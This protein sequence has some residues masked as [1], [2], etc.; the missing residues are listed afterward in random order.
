MMMVTMMMATV[1][2]VMA[3]VMMMAMM[4]TLVV[5]TVMTMSVVFSLRVIHHT[6][7]VPQ[8]DAAA[9]HSHSEYTPFQQEDYGIG[10]KIRRFGSCV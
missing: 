8:G 1:M 6:R 10:H 4:I 3:V 2:M 9:F 5:T 7:P